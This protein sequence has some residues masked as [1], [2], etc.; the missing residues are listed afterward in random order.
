MERQP[1]DS[2]KLWLTKFSSPFSSSH[3]HLQ[4]GVAAS[5]G[6]RHVIPP[7]RHTHFFLDSI[8]SLIISKKRGEK[9]HQAPSKT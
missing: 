5:G 1:T 4:S 6:G 8:D 9:E 2:S 7:H 3:R